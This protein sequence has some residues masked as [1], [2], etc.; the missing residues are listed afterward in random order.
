MKNIHRLLFLFKK[1]ILRIKGGGT[2]V[3]G[4]DG[5]TRH[6][7]I[8]TVGKIHGYKPTPKDVSE[9]D[10]MFGVVVASLNRCLYCNVEDPLGGPYHSSVQY[11]RP[12]LWIYKCI[13]S[14]TMLFTL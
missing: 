14:S 4:R 1:Q 11:N 2:G 5:S 7:L 8:V 13:E 9:R 10:K 3:K 6:G 12:Y